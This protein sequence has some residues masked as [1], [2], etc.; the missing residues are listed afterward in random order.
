MRTIQYRSNATSIFAEG[1]YY[2]VACG[3]GHFRLVTQYVD[4][5][6]FE[7]EI[8][9]KR[10]KHPLSVF[11]D[12]AAVDPSRCD[13]EYCLVTEM[14]DRTTFKRR[15]PGAAEVDFVTPSDLNAETGLY[16]SNRDAVRLVEYW[17]K[18]PIR[19][20]IARMETG[21]VVDVTDVDDRRASRPSHRRDAQGALDQGR[22]IPAEWGGSLDRPECMGGKVHPDLSR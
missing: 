20:T 22:A 3:I 21:E 6:E 16:W 1:M 18:V 13:A 4:D 5:N 14:V 8:R 15:F 9:I 17:R 12:P 19:R 11:W 2:A 10:I 7:Q